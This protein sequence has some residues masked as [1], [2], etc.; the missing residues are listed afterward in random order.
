MSVHV[1]EASC[2][3]EA[4]WAPIL[5]RIISEQYPLEPASRSD[6]WHGL[7]RWVVDDSGHRVGLEYKFDEKWARTGNAF[8]EIISNDRTRRPGWLESCQAT[9]LLYFLTPH[10]VLVY[11]TKRLRR[12]SQPWR[13]AYPVRRARNQGYSTL[14]LCVPV[15]VAQQAAESRSRL[16]EGDGIVLQEWDGWDGGDGWSGT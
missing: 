7:D 1:F 15:A 6:E 5:D 16:D 10:T 14:G 12:M 3:V 4:K 13:Q 9:W 2:A 8:F 11:L